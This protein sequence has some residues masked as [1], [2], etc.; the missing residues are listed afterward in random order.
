MTGSAERART[1][2]VGL[3]AVGGAALAA[4]SDWTSE[5]VEN[6]AGIASTVAR[7][8]SELAAWALPCALAAGAAFLAMLAA[9]RRTRRG[10]G[11]LAAAAGAAVAL[12][13]GLHA[14]QGPAPVGLAVAGVLITAAAL[15]AAIRS[16]RWPEPSARYASNPVD[17]G[18][19]AEDPAEL[20]NA[21]DSGR[22][23]SSP[24]ITATAQEKGRS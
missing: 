19:I 18:A 3:A 4:T 24:N 11:V 13:G 6:A 21:L 14:A 1:V 9:G 15:V 10:L 12:A 23:P 7:P 20:W 22:D 5:T 2:L 16:G 17:G 8:G